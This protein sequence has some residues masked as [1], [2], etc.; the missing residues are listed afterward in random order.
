MFLLISRQLYWAA[1]TKH[2]FDQSWAARDLI[3]SVC[4]GIKWG[5][6]LIRV[7][8]PWKVLI[9]SYFST[10]IPD[11]Q[12]SEAK[13]KGG[14]DL[15]RH[16]QWNQWNGNEFKALVNVTLFQTNLKG[17]KQVWLLLSWFTEMFPQLQ[18]ELSGYESS[19]PPR[20]KE[21]TVTKGRH[22][23]DPALVVSSELTLVVLTEENASTID[24]LLIAILQH[25]LYMWE[26][27]GEG[28]IISL[29][30]SSWAWQR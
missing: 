3:I 29:M 8:L 9:L 14:G 30:Q 21:Q 5:S 22:T 18:R 10:S 24:C 28:I 17:V 25:S 27:T 11:S 6:S 19:G 12:L 13:K 1:H 2:I 26:G 16:R 15:R 20:D 23:T 7:G 4:R